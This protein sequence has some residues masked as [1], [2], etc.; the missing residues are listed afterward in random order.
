MILGRLLG[1]STAGGALIL[2]TACG[3]SHTASSA[4]SPSPGSSAR[5]LSGKQLSSALLT[6][7]ETHAAGYAVMQKPEVEEPTATDRSVTPLSC[8]PLLNALEGG[9]GAGYSALA[10]E[11]LTADA[12][13][14]G[15]RWLT[16]A[17][18]HGDG[19]ARFVNSVRTAL[20]S[21]ASFSYPGKSGT[22]YVKKVAKVVVPAVGDDAVGF[23]AT[24]SPEVYWAVSIARH[25]NVTVAVTGGPDSS[26][27]R[28]QAQIL[29]QQ[30]TKLGALG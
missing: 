13:H 24:L 19:A 3:T 9:R 23:L 26:Q 15:D 16:L 1:V 22:A 27:P 4:A 14:G 28:I 6:G 29:E 25:G 20:G 18:F 17:H 30:I 21:C 11:G 10:S 8:Q 5:S 2:S 7:K 12:E